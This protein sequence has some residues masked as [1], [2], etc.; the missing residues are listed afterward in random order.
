MFFYF[1]IPQEVYKL[2]HLNVMTLM[3]SKQDFSDR[4]YI[5]IV[6]IKFHKHILGIK[7][8]CTLGFSNKYS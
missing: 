7:K 2:V 6:Y 5:V 3:N 8:F 1:Q 4:T